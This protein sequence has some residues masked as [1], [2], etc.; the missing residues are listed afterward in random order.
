[1]F[2]WFPFVFFFVT[3]IFIT[4]FRLVTVLGLVARLVG[5]VARLVGLLARFG[6]LAVAGITRVNC[7]D[8]VFEKDFMFSI[9]I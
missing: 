2:T 8:R 3:L 9:C 4:G 7:L 6:L 5:L 1:V